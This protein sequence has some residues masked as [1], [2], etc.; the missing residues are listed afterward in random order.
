MAS[1]YEITQQILGDKQKRQ[2][3][4]NQYCNNA[5]QIMN[6]IDDQDKK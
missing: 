2:G 3:G 1:I 6:Y 5:L 4:A